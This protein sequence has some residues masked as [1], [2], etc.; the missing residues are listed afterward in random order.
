MI[1]FWKFQEFAENQVWFN[2][3]VF[4]TS[5]NSARLSSVIEGEEVR[6]RLSMSCIQPG[7]VEDGDEVFEDGEV[8]SVRIS[9][10]DWEKASIWVSMLPEPDL[11]YFANIDKKVWLNG[12]VVSFDDM[13]FVSVAVPHPVGGEVQ[14]GNMRIEDVIHQLSEDGTRQELKA[15]EAVR[16]RVFSTLNR[17][18]T[19]S[20]HSKVVDIDD[21]RNTSV[22]EWLDAEVSGVNRYGL[23]VHV[24]PPG[25]EPGN[26]MDAI[27]RINR[28]P[29]GTAEDLATAFR[30]GQKVKVRV[31]NKDFIKNQITCSMRELLDPAWEIVSATEWIKAKVV[32]FKPSA[33]D[34]SLQPPGGGATA[35][36]V[37]ANPLIRRGLVREKSFPDEFSLDQEV[38]VRVISI[39]DDQ[40]ILSMRPVADL[41][42]FADLPVSAELAGIVVD[43]GPEGAVLSV[44]APTGGPAA[45]GFVPRADLEE[46][47]KELTIGKAVKVG[48]VC[49]SKELDRLDLTLKRTPLVGISRKLDLTS[50]LNLLAEIDENGW[51]NGTIQENGIREFGVFVQVAVAGGERLSGL[52]HKTELNVRAVGPLDKLFK[53]G[54]EVRVR[55]FPRT[56]EAAGMLAWTM[57]P[58][59]ES[60]GPA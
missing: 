10:I 25:A 55:K 13:F 2:A 4:R 44:P 20:M 36:S 47:G 56:G 54:Q 26:T 22:S 17:S 12:T 40:L 8:V 58:V 31:I 19:L 46:S 3:S 6:F 49:V 38:N 52:V 15:G 50:K 1:N 37:V 41:S 21:F 29:A 60:K 23:F 35:R 59:P 34:V 43:L 48:L 33:L 51:F 9:S 18:L 32:G 5:K 42:G 45:E 57:K 11:E 24:S 39:K 28:R 53:A 30:I 7:I 27:V 16:V 14:Y